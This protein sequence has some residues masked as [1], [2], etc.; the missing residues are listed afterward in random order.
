MS[1]AD[2]DKLTKS[3]AVIDLFNQ[4]E[5]WREKGYNPQLWGM[6]NGWGLVLDMT[7]S[8]LRDIRDPNSN[9]MLLRFISGVCSTPQAAIEAALKVIQP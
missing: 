9:E 8:G 1:E 4:L 5:T 7:H 2:I 3:W 6:H